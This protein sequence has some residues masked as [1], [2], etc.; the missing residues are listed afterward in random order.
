VGL[1]QATW[2]S[3]LGRKWGVDSIGKAQFFNNLLL[4]PW[5]LSSIFATLFTGISWMLAMMRFEISYDLPLVSLNFV[6][7]LIFWVFLFDEPFN[8][9]KVL[10]TILVIVGIVIITK[11]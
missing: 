5:V 4:N 6:K 9:A 1:V 2:T 10:G 7:L 3:T 11:S 8:S